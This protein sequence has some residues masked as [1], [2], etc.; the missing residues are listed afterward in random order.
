MHACLGLALDNHMTL[1]HRLESS[2]DELS[3]QAA[4]AHPA[5]KTFIN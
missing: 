1:E 3:K 2:W 5:K 4:A